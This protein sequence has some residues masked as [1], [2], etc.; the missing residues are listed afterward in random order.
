M[1]PPTPASTPRKRIQTEHD[2]GSEQHERGVAVSVH[3][4]RTCD[5]DAHIETDEDT[6]ADADDRCCV[7]ENQDDG[8]RRHDHRREPEA[9]FG[10]DA[11]IAALDGI[12]SAGALHA[13]NP[14]VL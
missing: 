2:A 8:D 1:T 4:A 13:L 7:A 3:S 5:E 6:G 14:L 11:V 9:E 10:R 12:S